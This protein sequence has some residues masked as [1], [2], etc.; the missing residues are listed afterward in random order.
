MATFLDSVNKVL[1]I[2]TVIADDD[3]DLTT[4][5]STQ[6]KGTLQLAKIAIQSTITELTAD[7][8]IPAEQADDTITYVDGT[9][10]YSLA[11]DF[12]R[13]SD[14]NPFFLELDGSGNS[15]N[16][17]VCMYPGGEKQ[18][19]REILNYR[20]DSG[21][22][23][24]FYPIESTTKQIGFWKVPDSTVDGLQHRYYYEKSVYPTT[25][26]DTMPFSSTQEADTFANMAARYWQFLYTK[27]PIEE[28]LNDVVYQRNKASLIDLMS[29]FY[30][31]TSY[32]YDYY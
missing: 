21:K 4:F 19:R 17:T 13:F 32:G 30:K 10:I 23:N 22:P 12:V 1:R 28:L 20:S 15:A 18:L 29:Q 24:Y 27:Q 31:S 8:L 26:A 14:E 11:S 5:N 3:D 7:R 9:R 6:H 16:T 2:N 25:E